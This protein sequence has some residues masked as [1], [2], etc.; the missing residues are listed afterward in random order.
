MNLG[1]GPIVDQKALA[2]ALEEGKIAGA[3]LDVLEREPLELSDELLKIQDS[4]KLI[5]T[6]HIAWATCEA[7]KRCVQEVYENIV[8]WQKGERRNVVTE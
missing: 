5:V 3:G 7:R 1:R 6:P 8:S 2:K 4:T